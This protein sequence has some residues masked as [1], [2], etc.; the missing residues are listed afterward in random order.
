MEANNIEW[1]ERFH[2]QIL[3]TINDKYETKIL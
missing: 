3:N 2:S 1:R